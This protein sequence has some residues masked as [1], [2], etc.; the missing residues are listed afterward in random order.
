ME[1][2]SGRVVDKTVNGDFP[3][4]LVRVVCAD[5][6]VVL[7]KEPVFADGGV[8]VLKIMPVHVED[9]SGARACNI[10]WV[11][12]LR[13]GLLQRVQEFHAAILVLDDEHLFHAQEVRGDDDVPESSYS[14]AASI[15]DHMGL[16][17]VDSKSRSRVDTGV[18]TCH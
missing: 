15:A 5:S 6:R 16:A 17:W 10:I 11:Q 1:L 7:D 14:T 3:I 8:G 9:R 12:Q 4:W 18:D 2:S 13:D